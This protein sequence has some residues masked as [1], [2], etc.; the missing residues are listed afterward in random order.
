MGSLLFVVVVAACCCCLCFD[1]DAR[2]ILSAAR[3]RLFICLFAYW[4]FCSSPGRCDA[5]RDKQGEKEKGKGAGQW[6]MCMGHA[7]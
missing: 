5:L 7:P 1:C 6:A 3:E 2:I 4:L